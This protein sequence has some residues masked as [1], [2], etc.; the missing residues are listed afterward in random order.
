M[1]IVFLHEGGHG[2]DP[3]SGNMNSSHSTENMACLIAGRAGGLR[4]GEHI[5]LQNKQP[6]QVLA[7]AMN[8]VGVPTTGLGEVSGTI[9]ELIG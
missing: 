5:R 2:L 4:A 1:A 9:P 8:A 3:S 7:T 6:A